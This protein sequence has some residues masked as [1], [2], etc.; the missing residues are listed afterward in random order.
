MPLIRF[1]VNRVMIGKIMS[2][3]IGNI[4]DFFFV[5]FN[6][7]CQIK[8]MAFPRTTLKLQVLKK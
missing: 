5:I 1:A 3:N 6:I 4:D 2:K 8:N 7:F